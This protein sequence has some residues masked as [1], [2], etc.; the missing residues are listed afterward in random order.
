VHAAC[1]SAFY[2][3]NYCNGTFEDAGS[4]IKYSPNYEWAEG[5]N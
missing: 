5:D 1:L 4:L 2:D 3:N